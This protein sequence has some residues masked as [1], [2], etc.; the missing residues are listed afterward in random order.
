MTATLEEKTSPMM[1]Q[2]H[3]CKKKAE[4][5]VLLFR[6]GDFYEAF[7][8]DAHTLSKELDITLTQRQGI[9]MAGIP[10]HT[11]EAYVDR[12][13][14][15]G[16]HVAIA[17]QVEDAK[18]SKGLVKREIVQI[19]T[20]A[21]VVQSALLS[22]KKS[23]FLA[24]LS[25]L[26]QTLGLSVLDI[27]TAEF[28]VF[29]FEQFSLLR[30]ELTR[31]KP[32][33]LLLSEKCFK[34]HEVDLEEL[35][36]DL[37]VS[38]LIRQDWHFNYEHTF[39]YLARHFCVQ[40]LAGFGLQE[41]TASIQAAG[42]LLSY[43]SED[44]GLNV[45][46]IQTIKK[47]NSREY[48]ALDSTTL[49]HLEIL[50]NTQEKE[51]KCTLLHHLDRTSTPMGGR[52][53]WHWISHP[54]LSVEK[55]QKRQEAVSFFYHFSDLSLL[56]SH[57]S[58]IRDLERLI[59]RIETGFCNPKDLLALR[60]SLEAFPQV[61]LLLKNAS[62][63]LILEQ[64][65]NLFDVSFLTS[66]LKDTLQED[67]PLRL[68]DGNVIKQGVC[69]ELD[70]LRAICQNDQNWIVNYQVRLREDTGIK[71]LKVGYT[72]A[73]GY[74]IEV[75]RGQAEKIP[76]SFERRQTLVNAERFITKELKEYEY[77]VLSAEEKIAAMEAELFLALRKE[78]SSY[79]K[80]I[81]LAASAIAHIDCLASFAKVAKEHNYVCPILDDGQKFSIQ[82]GRHPVIEAYLRSDAFIPNDVYL[83]NENSR[84]LLITGPNMAGKS[85][86]I[87]QVA[88]IAILAQIGSFV[89]A[90]SAH[91]GIIDKVFTRIGASDNLAKGQSTFMVEMAETASILHNAT[92]RSLVILDEI[93]RGTSTYDG[94]SI[95]WA[96]AEY[97]LTTEGKKAK[98]LFAT[99]YCELIQL[100]EKIPGALNYHIAVHE[101]SQGIVFLRKIVRGGTDKSYGL[102]VAKLAGIPS[103]V[104]RKAEQRLKALE[105]KSSSKLS[106]PKE[107]QLSFF[108][109]P[110]PSPEH[111][112]LGEI[113]ALDI[114]NMTPMQAL[115]KLAHWK[116]TTH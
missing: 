68:S 49:R 38:L 73:F 79:A 110:L 8:A 64:S 1:M 46:H 91:M 81:R 86:F 63:P 43:L 29:E 6:L 97:L 44:L 89:P 72:K 109:I 69:E 67:P 62:C 103:T 24:S 111:P 5:A 114:N 32:R 100:E 92:D 50:E 13:V 102:H 88:L 10:F 93:G 11:S 3:A 53:I 25:K 37:G 74:Y 99:H 41:M 42:C 66:R 104:I 84:L 113:R 27:T 70:S 22:E 112:L 30:D 2:W 33:E 16:Y 19:I 52:L 60:L 7:H 23:N 106:F 35:K 57:L 4:S 107:E 78:I 94:I 45:Q 75:S 26:N 105:K 116:K 40:S 85:T 82:G 14:S 36:K 76:V 108:Q 21:T 98:T 58:N 101:S 90:T 115:E 47:E 34:Y 96:V 28:K 51:S 83:D 15:K 87:R 39:E 31:L 61:I 48:M 59:M 20:P 18:E 17:E 54:L 80:A 56:F 77:K 65:L 55:I 12:L 9:P 95:A 71:T